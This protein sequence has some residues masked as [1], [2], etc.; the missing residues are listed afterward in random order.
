MLQDAVGVGAEEENDYALV[1]DALP[2]GKLH[3]IRSIFKGP[4]QLK[5]AGGERYV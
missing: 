3:R 1:A 2:E 4:Q 5:N